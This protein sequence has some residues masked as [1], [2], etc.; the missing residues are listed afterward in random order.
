[1]AADG[2]MRV[3]AMRIE[4]DLRVAMPDGVELATS[5]FVPA[6]TPA[7]AVLIRSP[8]GRNGAVSAADIAIYARAGYAVVTQDVRGRYESQGTFFPFENEARDGAATIDWIAA[9]PWS[10]GEV[11]MTGESYVGVTQWLAASSHPTALKAIAPAATASDLYQRWCYQGGALQLGFLLMW[12]TTYLAAADALRYLSSPEAQPELVAALM[13]AADDMDTAY[14][15]LPLN[16]QPALAHIAP[17]YHQWIAHPTYDDFWKQSSPPDLHGGVEIPSLSIGGWYDLFLGG[18]LA[19]YVAMRGQAGNRAGRRPRLMIG[20]W[21]HGALSGEYAEAQFGLMGN[22]AS[23]SMT[24]QEVAFFDTVRAQ[25]AGASESAPPVRLF[26]MGSNEW[27]DGDD[28]P[29]P[30]TV[31]TP[32]YLHSSGGAGSSTRDGGLSVLEPDDEPPD[33]YRYDPGDPVPTVG[34]QSFLPGLLV[35]ANAGPRDQRSVE[36]RPDVL[37]FTTSPLD[38]PLTVIGPVSL[39]L[40][41]SSS[42]AD[43]D[44]TGKLVDVHPDGRAVILTEGILRAR[45]RASFETPT[46]LQADEVYQLTIDLVA[47]AN[48]FHAGHRIRLEISS[49]NFPR[50]DRNTNSGGT[51]ADETEADFVIATNTVYHD[52]PRPSHLLLPITAT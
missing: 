7:P 25:S 35:C 43:T 20:P 26:V 3:D 12:A 33:T 4:W 2:S 10:S 13:A 48:V 1:M 22:H 18:T 32:Y 21:A 5:I 51:I 46:P 34:G 19:S 30:D 41:V 45:Y 36:E 27:R 16:D 37:C 29:L 52:A 49:S 50:F 42:A 9:Q 39:V 44:F 11:F 40:Y 8:Y 24:E 31:F 14:R 47:T 15:R 17:Y 23:L 38:S 28:W 6:T